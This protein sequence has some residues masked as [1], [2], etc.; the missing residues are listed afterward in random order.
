MERNT[1]ISGTL[2]IQTRETKFFYS[3]ISPLLF[4]RA[5]QRDTVKGVV[6]V[7]GPPPLPQKKRKKHGHARQHERNRVAF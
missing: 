2:E 1:G 4:S 7:E 5:K 6:S 3:L